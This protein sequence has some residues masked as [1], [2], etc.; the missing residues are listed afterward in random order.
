MNTVYSN[1]YHMCSKKNQ[2]VIEIFLDKLKTWPTQDYTASRDFIY[3][4]NAR[5]HGRLNGFVIEEKGF[6]INFFPNAQQIAFSI[7]QPFQ[8]NSTFEISFSKYLT[9]NALEVTFFIST[10]IEPKYGLGVD[11]DFNSDR[12]DFSLTDCFNF[13]PNKIK[14]ARHEGYGDDIY[15]FDNGPVINELLNIYKNPNNSQ[16]FRDLL[17]LK[18]D[19][20]IDND[21]IASAILDS[22][23]HYHSL[24]KKN[25]NKLTQNK[26]NK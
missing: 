21:E 25:K 20:V 16:E 26:K 7:K 13:F 24:L 10:L 4:Y 1:F 18:Y 8:D 15:L 9:I 11:F 3:E 22:S 2:K 6:N 14:S 17:L 5:E 12:G 19:I 23:Q